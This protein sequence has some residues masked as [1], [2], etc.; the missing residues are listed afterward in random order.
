MSVEYIING[1]D[2]TWAWVMKT[3][4]PKMQEPY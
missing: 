3:S 4:I 2:Q 1:N